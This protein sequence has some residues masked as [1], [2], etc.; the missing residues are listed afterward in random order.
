MSLLA[1]GRYFESPRWHNERLWVTD[2]PV[3]RV[4]NLTLAGTA[5]TVCEIDDIPGGLGF[6]PDGDMIVVGMFQRKLLR[7]A[8]G[9]VERYADLANVSGG[10]LD[11]MVVDGK[12][13]AYV[14]DLGA[15]LIKGE[16]KGAIGRIV[17]VTPD[18]GSRVVAEGLQFPNGLAISGDGKE[19]VV[20]ESDGDC[21]SHF[22]IEA[23]G[24]LRFVRRFGSFGEP[25]GVCFDREGCVWTALFKEDAFVRLDLE[26]RVLQ[27]VSTLG[28]RGVACVLG[29]AERRTLFCLSAETTHQDLMRG[30]SSARID[31]IEVGVA[32]AG[33]P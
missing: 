22:K 2:G 20:A 7:H 27:R 28:G 32:G 1:T 5:E 10:T 14:G 31:M 4:L 12:G 13:R 9:R 18:G 3:R 15:S 26:G 19:L 24:A 25:D 30:K 21:L 16:V 33:Y 23:D 11:D 29:G 6:L 8:R 17:L